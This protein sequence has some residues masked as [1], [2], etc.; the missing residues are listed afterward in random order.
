MPPLSTR[1]RRSIRLVLL[2]VLSVAFVVFVLWLAL[3]DLSTASAWA[4]VLGLFLTLGGLILTLAEGLGA[5]GS[6]LPA[7]DQLAD[8]LARTVQDSWREEAVARGLR[9]AGVLPLA[10][11]AT[12]RAVS[13]APHNIVGQPPGSP[14]VLRLR[15]DGRLTGTLDESA[16]ALAAAYRQVPSGRLVVLG[17]PGAG[18]TVLALLLTLGLLDVRGPGEPVPVLLAPSGWDPVSEPLDDWIVRTVAALYYRGQRE[19]PRLLLARGLLLPIVDG[20]DEISEEARRSAVK[21]ID[22]AVGQD[23]PVVVTCRSAEYEDV[24]TA[25]SPTPATELHTLRRAPVVEVARVPAE[26]AITYLSDVH[27]PPGTDWNPVYAHLRTVSDSPVATALTTPLMIS[28]A[29]VVHER[30]GGDPA[31]LLDQSTF[32]SRHAV[33]DHLLGQLVRAAYAPDRLPSGPPLAPARNAPDTADALRWLTYLAR[34]LHRWRERD[35]AWWLLPGR[36]FSAWTGP[37]LGLAVAVPV[38]T[39]VTAWLL[40]AGFPDTANLPGAPGPVTVGAFA[41]AGTGVVVTITWYAGAVRRPGRLAFTL[42]GSLSRLRRGLWYG[43]MVT[44]VPGLTAV[45]AAA[46][47]ISVGGGWSYSSTRHYCT[48]V[49]VGVMLCLTVSLGLAVQS[50]LD[51]APVRSAHADPVALLREDRRAALVGALAAGVITALLAFPAVIAGLVAGYLMNAALTGWSGEPSRAQLVSYALD[52]V[53]GNRPADLTAATIA[54]LVGSTVALLTCLP[55]PWPR[56]ALTTLVLAVRG[57]LPWRSMRFLTDARAREIL[58]QSGGTFQFRHA[59]L[60]ERLVEQPYA[61]RTPRRARNAAIAVAAAAAVLASAGSLLVHHMPV[62]TSRATLLIRHPGGIDISADGT[63]LAGWHGFTGQTQLWDLRH[64][65]A[66]RTLP[67]GWVDSMAVSADGRELATARTDYRGNAIIKVWNTRSA[68]VVSTFRV[69]KLLE[70]GLDRLEFSPD[71]RS[72]AATFND[73]CEVKVLDAATGKVRITLHTHCVVQDLAFEAGGHALTTV[74]DTALNAG[75]AGWQVW[76]TTSGKLLKTAAFGEESETL[77]DRSGRVIALAGS[78]TYTFW[79]IRSGRKISYAD[80]AGYRALAFSEDGRLFA[81]DDPESND[82]IVIDVATGRAVGKPTKGHRAQVDSAA[83]SADD[84]TLVTVSSG[85][86]TAKFW[87]V[88]GS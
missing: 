72:L 17:E 60:Q 44:G 13:D 54:G 70:Q 50:W 53:P 11:A 63:L 86:G 84:R 27:W 76:D 48:V 64:R 87:N 24:I 49:A 25:G 18:K 7:P 20:L 35:F 58:R 4:G 3:D 28:L 69:E 74:T 12:R 38:M 83:F 10:W 16:E 31:E 73:S 6:A 19:V 42:R 26:A 85:D 23:R 45:V 43:L 51:A 1:Q 41:G 65:K 59:R 33:E 79:N 32:R 68:R 78:G 15:L 75:H 88:A 34:H 67:T 39:V 22:H 30:L 5:A 9:R 29:R 56:F 77:I 66:L 57:R 21:G 36:A 14:L 52:I 61:A 62:D 82:V 55:R 8:D 37:A 40:W 46:V 47:G 2:V 81:T 71:G 80:F